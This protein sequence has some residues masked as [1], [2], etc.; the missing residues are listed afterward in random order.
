R[1]CYIPTA[2]SFRP[3]RQWKLTFYF[4][5][6]PFIPSKMKAQLQLISMAKSGKS[7]LVYCHH[8]CIQAIEF[9]KKELLPQDQIT[10]I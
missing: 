5:N 3:K 6:P 9:K 1:E 2:M 7:D 8:S 10:E 4:S